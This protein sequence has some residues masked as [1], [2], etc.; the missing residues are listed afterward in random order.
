MILFQGQSKTPKNIFKNIL[1]M[2]T[3]IT[4]YIQIF[5]LLI[6]IYILEINFQKRCQLGY[7]GEV[8][9]C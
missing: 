2:A 1:Q 3:A 9:P 4:Y 8:F 5:L 6:K 7:N